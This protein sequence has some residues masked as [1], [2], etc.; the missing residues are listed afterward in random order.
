MYDICGATYISDAVL[1]ETGTRQNMHPRGHEYA[2]TC[3]NGCIITGI[4]FVT[5][6]LG[7]VGV[8]GQS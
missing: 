8:P 3:A 2:P 5:N 1:K 7:H 6:Y 4:Y